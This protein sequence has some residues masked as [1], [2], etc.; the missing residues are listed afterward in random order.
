M[1]SIRKIADEHGLIIIDDAAHAI[2]AVYKTKDG[3][4]WGYHLLQFYITKNMT[5][6]EGGMVTSENQSY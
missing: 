4:S 5:T 6:V 1:D 2:E 3:A